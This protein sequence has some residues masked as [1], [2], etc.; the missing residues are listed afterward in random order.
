M[1]AE[2]RASGRCRSRGRGP[3]PG[4][5]SPLRRGDR[6][7]TLTLRATAGR[8]AAQS[9]ATGFV[10][11]SR[12]GQTRRILFWLRVTAPQLSRLPARSLSRTGDYRGNTRGRRAL[13][14]SYRYPEDP[15]GIGVE[16]SLRGPS[17]SSVCAYAV[18]WRTSGVA[19]LTRSRVQP[20]IVIGADENHQAG[21]TALPLQNN[22]YLPTFL[23]PAPIAAVIRPRRAPTTLSSTARPGPAPGAFVSG[24]GSTTGPRRG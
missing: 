14:P 11:L 6:S 9:D 12:A 3:A 20:R 16:R 15:S 8:A 13:I 1:R 21:S 7:G 17:R 19:L 24:S 2:A 22:P 4:S 18:R 23:D 10:T 5:R